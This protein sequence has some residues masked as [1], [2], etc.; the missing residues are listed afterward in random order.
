M[1]KAVAEPIA[2]LQACH[3]QEPGNGPGGRGRY[4]AKVNHGDPAPEP[5]RADEVLI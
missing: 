3:H 1:E 5:N 2:H 4:R